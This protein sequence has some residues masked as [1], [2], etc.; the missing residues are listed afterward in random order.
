MFK[1]NAKNTGTWYSGVFYIKFEHISHLS[2]VF[3]ILTS[4]RQLLA[5]RI[6]W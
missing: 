3:L 2:L 4:N 6:F 1:D 5:G